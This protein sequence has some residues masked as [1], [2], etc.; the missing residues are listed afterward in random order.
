MMGRGYLELDCLFYSI[1]VF[2]SREATI[3]PHFGRI[4]TRLRVTDIQDF[5]LIL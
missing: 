3:A 5:Q 2:L 4:L 1:F